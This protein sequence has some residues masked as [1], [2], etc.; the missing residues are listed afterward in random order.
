MD[1][2]KD[3]AQL[4]DNLTCPAFVVKEGVIVNVN[5]SAAQHNIECNTN[6]QNIISIG[7]EEYNR[8]QDGKL[9]LT[10]TINEISYNAVVTAT[11][12]LH[13]F[14]LTSD[15]E[16]AELRAYALAAMNL[17]EPL[18]NA[19][20]NTE[21]LLP[22]ESIQSDP[23]VMQMLA[24]VNRNLHQLLRAIG[25]MSDT[26]AYANQRSFRMQTRDVVSVIEEILDKTA[27]LVESSG[28]TLNYKLPSKAIYSL[29]DAEKL[30][31]AILN[32]I[33]NAMKYTSEN[34]KLDVELRQNNH[35]LI[36]T[37][38]DNGQGITPQVRGNLFTRFLREPGIED[39][40]NG[41]GLGLSIVRSVA[42][43]HGGTVLFEQPDNCGARITMTMSIQKPTGTVL[44][45]QIK[46]PIEYT[47]GRDHALLELSDVLPDTLYSK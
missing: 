22:N 32:L 42:S 31:R 33:S 19:M 6:I 27:D 3:S 34:G 5:Q 7:T 2:F 29:I 12:D 44:H 20:L 15:Y 36:L 46:L 23:Q 4:L 18:S 1:H 28:K 25:N 17:R 21:Q 11:D 8:F 43:A 26:A 9:C 39:G 24:Q 14:C 13:I 37:I 41:I 45:D 16:D 35:M 47:G 40:R 30:E 10:L 38:Q